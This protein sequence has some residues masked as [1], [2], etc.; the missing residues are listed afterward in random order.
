MGERKR[1]EGRGAGD[2]EEKEKAKSN[3]GG[4]RIADGLA[5]QPKMKTEVPNRG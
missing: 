4:G 5:E 3:R 2:A 1:E